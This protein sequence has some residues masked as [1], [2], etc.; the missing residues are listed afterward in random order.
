MPLILTKA[1]VQLQCV[2][3]CE[4]VYSTHKDI[5]NEIMS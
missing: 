3:A 2:G 5:C 1:G 4:K